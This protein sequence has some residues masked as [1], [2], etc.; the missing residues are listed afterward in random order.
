M[1]A[2]ALSSCQQAPQKP[3]EG[4]SK[5]LARHRASVIDSLQ[6]DISLTIPDSLS[7]PVV[8]KTVIRLRT[9]DTLNNL[10]LD[11]APADSNLN[12]VQFDQ[13]AVDYSIRNGHIILHPEK[14]PIA[15]GPHTIILK[16]R[17]GNEPL[18]RNKEY[19]YS[20]FVP[21]RASHALPLFD[22]P[23]LK[24]R[25][26]LTL[27]IPSHWKAVSNSPA[28]SIHHLD[29]KTR[30]RF[31]RTPPLPT[32]LFS[33]V[34]GDF[35]LETADRNG[36]TLRFFHR[37]TD[38]AKV[39]RNREQIFD[40]HARSLQWLEE[41]TGI[42][43]PFEKFDFVL[44]P[45]FQYGGMEHPGAI[46]YRASRIFLDESA[47]QQEKLGQAGLIAHETAHMWFG[48][49]VTM[50]W[51]NDVWTKEVFANFMAAKIV[52]PSFPEI[53]HDQRFILEHFPPSYG[54]DRTRGT[55][56]IR[57]SLGNLKNAG[58]LYGSLIY[59]K[60]PIVMKKLEKMMGPD[61]MQ[62][63][64]QIY[65][66][67]Y[68]WKSA[69]WNDLIAVFDSVS[70]Q[71]IAR[72]SQIWVEEAG[73]P[74]ITSQPAISSSSAKVR[75]SQS[76]PL[77]QN[78]T[79][80]QYLTVETQFDGKNT[81]KEIL[82]D[83]P[84]KTISL[85]TATGELN[86]LLP[87]ADGTGYGLFKMD[88]VS[89]HSLLAELPR[90]SS[91]KKRAVIWLDLW[92]NFL[93]QRIR[94]AE[95]LDLATRALPAESNAMN[96][97]QILGYLESTYWRYASDS[98]RDEYTRPLEKLLWNQ[99]QQVDSAS[100]K[101]TYFKSFRDIASSD[102]ALKKL[103]RVWNRQLDIP[104]LS[105]STRD[106][107]RMAAALSIHEY[108]NVDSLLD[109]QQQRIEN[110]D[111]LKRF[112]FIRPALSPDAETRDDF[113][114]RLKKPENRS[115]EPWVIDAVRYLH[116]PARKEHARKYLYPSLKMLEEMERTGDIFFPKSWLDATFSGHNTMEAALVVKSFLEVRETYPHFLKQKMLQSIDPL[117]RAVE[118]RENIQ[119]NLEIPRSR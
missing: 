62:Q 107:T 37:E 102:T 31:K 61:H 109:R 71:N 1:G 42:A 110:P 112:K 54:V 34:A 48:D 94:P 29:G 81:T 79:W 25:F 35:M 30:Y 113:F 101:S 6:Y 78:R 116:H 100:L 118:M 114:N 12:H 38:S 87:N 2:L 59:H 86:Y 55:H 82:F 70:D 8:G 9:T 17:A 51:F 76:D 103:Y 32:Y 33:F 80:P 13:A 67:R 28:D 117:F 57:Q 69:R 43:H 47:T 53:D 65:L 19:L 14:S 91:P 4:V 21:A 27:T 26:Q 106:Y 84:Q 64:L 104:K 44:I 66:G 50:E 24:G 58:S 73:R 99:V 22:Q 63:G 39:A 46:L 77:Q 56:P 40:L 11:F 68:R 7:K 105:F 119:M 15:P 95:I 83:T 93:E 23:N 5:K 41:Y 85:D 16:Y 18:N 36:R 10:T 97:E 89:L 92:E 74:I 88:S 98:L 111:R 20:L 49:L 96:T 90:I 45:G 75:F 60:A 3:S 72:W 108:G 52:H 115:H